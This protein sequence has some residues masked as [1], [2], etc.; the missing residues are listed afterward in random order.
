MTT[1]NPQPSII[2]IYRDRRAWQ[3][4]MRICVVGFVFAGIALIYEALWG[5]KAIGEADLILAL[6]CFLSYVLSRKDPT[7]QNFIWWPLLGGIWLTSSAFLY[8][9]GGPHSPYLDEI[10]ILLFAAGIIV[11]TR[12]N[13]RQV[14]AFVVTN[15]LFW[16]LLHLWIPIPL[17]IE[18]ETRLPFGREYFFALITLVVLERFF[19][20]E[21]VLAAEAEQKTR[22]LEESRD[23]L[24]HSSRLA[25]IGSLLAAAG[26]ELSQPIQ[27]IAL[28]SS[29][30]NRQLKQPHP[31]IG[32][33]KELVAHLNQSADRLNRTLV[34]FR[35]FSRKDRFTPQRFDLRE[36]LDKI[37]SL[38][39]FDLR[40]RKIALKISMPPHALP[41]QG[42]PSRIEQILFNLIN[43]ARDASAKTEKPWIEIDARPYA[44]WARIR[45]TNNGPA[46]PLEVQQ[47]LFERFF[48]TKERGKGTG[49][50]LPICLDLI[51]QH[52]GRILFSS[53]ENLTT[54][55]VDL[56]LATET[57]AKTSAA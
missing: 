43:N 57:E 33:M 22:E 24:A 1:P 8:Y 27:T 41:V 53:E 46:I 2:Q 28:S 26:H 13:I 7:R 16:A 4:G 9:S 23:E 40:G 45:V 55:V 12:F 38:T 37:R 32:T 17:R 34:A 15:Y 19:R 10:L 29:L 25:E 21:E 36:A 52:S 44:N 30:L 14:S 31:D 48:T 3:A 47:R 39:E 6:G 35:D 18:L 49:L 42:D 51:K 56:P 54:F 5:N 50:G 20:T 11:Q